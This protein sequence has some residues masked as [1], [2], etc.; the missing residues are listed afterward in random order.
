M[1]ARINQ[2]EAVNLTRILR[3]ILFTE[4]ESGIM[5]VGRSTGKTFVDHT[6]AAHNCITALHFCRPT[7]IEAS[8]VEASRNVHGETHELV[9]LDCL[10]TCVFQYSKAGQ[11]SFVQCKV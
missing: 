9:Q 11:S 5:L 1:I 7:T 10:L 6:A 4:Q 3:C 2:I 8:H